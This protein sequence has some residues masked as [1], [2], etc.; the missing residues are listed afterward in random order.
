MDHKLGFVYTNKVHPLINKL[1]PRW[2]LIGIML[3]YSKETKRNP[4]GITQ[5]QLNHSVKETIENI[6]EKNL[7]KGIKVQNLIELKS[8]K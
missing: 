2:K 1:N 7:L 4:S 3:S 8:D 5:V 6:W